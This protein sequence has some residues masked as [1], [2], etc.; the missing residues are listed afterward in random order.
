[1]LGKKMNKNKISFNIFFLILGSIQNYVYGSFFEKTN[2]AEQRDYGGWSID[3]ELFDYIRRILP[4]GKTILELGSGWASGELSKYYTVYSIEHDQAWVGKNNT[5]Y[6]YAPIKNGW[7]DIDIL[8]TQLP[9]QYDLILVDGP[10]KKIGRS[11]F[12]KHIY[13]FNTTIPIIFDDIN[14]QDEFELLKNAA[15]FLQRKFTVFATSSIKQFG[16][17]DKR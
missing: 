12:F 6:I 13:L 2:Y 5:N 8:R 15:I 16:V 14:R 3:K 11:G 10:P 9:R 1:M 17:I 7:Y 4:E